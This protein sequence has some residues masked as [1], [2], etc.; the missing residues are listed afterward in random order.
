MNS[1]P[2]TRY[3][4]PTKVV[5][6][7]SGG[8]DSAVSAALLKE[9]GHD[10]VGMT[11]QVQPSVSLEPESERFGGCCSITD[12]EDARRVADKLDIPHYVLNFRDIF[13]EKVINNFIDE[14][15]Q[16][17]TPNPCIKCNQLIKF[18]ALFKKALSL[19]ADFIATGHYA[20]IRKDED[21]GRYL[22]LRG[23]DKHKDQS[24]VLYMMTQEQLSRA[25]FPLGDLTKEKSRAIAKKIGLRV[26]DKPESQEICFIPD[27]D[28]RRFLKEKIPESMKNGLIKDHEGKVI[29][30]HEGILNYT[31]GQRKGL[32]ISAKEPL[33][34]LEIDAGEN[35]IVVGPV[36]MLAQDE[37]IADELN[38]IAFER[39][40]KKTSV[41]AKI[42]YNMKEV[43][44]YLEPQSKEKVKVSFKSPQNAI[45]P[46]QAVV[47]YD[48]EVVIGGATIEKARNLQKK[49][50]F[51][52]S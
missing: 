28:Y 18:E 22:L 36:E 11:M 4:K 37:L 51:V 40:E 27:D 29:G 6:A 19:E 45:T 52:N 14:Y 42:R 7:M 50:K 44:A 16:G 23:K 17:R 33:F 34:V 43:P 10:V 30:E 32:G 2:D 5:V 24:Y 46:G 1:K 41:D 3:S 8:V 25:L 35:S 38:L 15:S 49:P 12:I 13:N 47:F 39:L 20:R 21:S 31:I 26:A 48:G 9:Q